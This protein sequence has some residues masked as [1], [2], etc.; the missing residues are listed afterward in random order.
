MLK[1][2]GVATVMLLTNSPHKVRS[3]REAG[4]TVAEVGPLHGT[5]NQ[6]NERYI[7]TKQERAGHLR[8]AN[9]QSDG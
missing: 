6:H 1:H 4:I 2:L 8:P 5:P 7:R 3:L 9:E